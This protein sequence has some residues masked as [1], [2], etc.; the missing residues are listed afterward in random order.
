MGQVRNLM[1]TC[2]VEKNILMKT[3]DS[4]GKI[5]SISTKL[6]EF[7]RWSIITERTNRSQS[8]PAGPAHP[9]FC[10]GGAS[11]TKCDASSTNPHQITYQIIWSFCTHKTERDFWYFIKNRTWFLVTQLKQT[12]ILEKAWCNPPPLKLTKISKGGG[13]HQ[14]IPLMWCQNSCNIIFFAFLM[15]KKYCQKYC[16]ISFKWCNISVNM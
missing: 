13:L 7:P 2:T 12:H 11:S 6:F 16:N 4:R 8:P 5:I 1:K 14:G 10:A 3:C 9:Y 15:G